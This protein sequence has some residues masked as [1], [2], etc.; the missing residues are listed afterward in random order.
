MT[1]PDIEKFRFT[2][3]AMEGACGVISLELTTQTPSLF[4]KSFVLLSLDQPETNRI[5]LSPVMM[6]LLFFFL[7]WSLSRLYAS[8]HIDHNSRASSGFVLSTQGCFRRNAN[9]KQRT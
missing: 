4:L 3:P 1:V 6:D 2:T 8:G 9:T 5:L 7:R